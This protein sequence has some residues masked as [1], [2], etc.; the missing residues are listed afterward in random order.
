MSW[1]NS[2][3]LQGNIV[4]TIKVAPVINDSVAPERTYEKERTIRVKVGQ[5]I[6][7]KFSSSKRKTG[8]DT[9][10]GKGGNCNP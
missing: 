1:F 7:A 9:E 3:T 8:A 4:H 10:G 6:L 2:I 5:Y